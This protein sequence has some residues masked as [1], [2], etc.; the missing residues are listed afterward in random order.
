MGCRTTIH[1]MSRRSIHAQVS[2]HS[3]HSCS[4]RASS[5]TGTTTGIASGETRPGVALPTGFGV[6]VHYLEVLRDVAIART[7]G[8]RKMNPDLA[9]IISEEGVRHVASVLEPRRYP[10]VLPSSNTAAERRDLTVRTPP[11]DPR[12]QH[13]RW[14]L[15]HLVNHEPQRTELVRD[16]VIATLELSNAP[17]HRWR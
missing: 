2:S 6:V 10:K 15:R 9:H 12:H 17:K 14:C 7:A 3:M 13:P 4:E 11:S 5:S 8:R 1:G 16:M